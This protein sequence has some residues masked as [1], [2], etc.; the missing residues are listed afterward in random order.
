MS[1]R[2]RLLREFDFPPIPD[3]WEVINLSQILSSERGISVGVMYPGKHDPEGIPLIRAGDL[4][5]NRIEN[6]PEFRISKSVNQEYKRTILE[7]G[8]LLISLV[9]D[10]GRVAVVPEWAKGWN[11]ARAIGV[12]RISP[13]AEAKYVRLVLSTGPLQKIMRAWAN[14]T[15]QA[16]L[17]LKEIK[18]LPLPWPKKGV[19][20]NIVGIADA[21]EN[22]IELNRQMNRTLEQMARAL[23]KSWFIDFDPVHAKQRGEQPAGMDAET[24]ALFP[25]RFVEVDGKEVPE[26]WRIS[27]V[28][29]M[30]ENPRRSVNPQSIDGR[31]PYIGLEHMPRG[32]I[33]LD[34]WGKAEDID[35][36]KVIFEKGEVLF[37]RLRPYFKKV[38]IA[39][40]D[41]ISSIDILIL[42]PKINW[43]E[44]ALF[45]V[46]SDEFIDAM[47]GASGGTRMPRASWR[48]LAAYPLILPPETLA[49]AYSSAVA[50]IIE[51]I[52]MCTFESIE[53]AYIRNTLLPRLLSGEL[54]VSD[55]E[56]AVE[57]PESTPA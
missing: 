46:S 29:S 30:V 40:F 14:T 2:E 56:H 11:P 33:G 42:K 55:W 9:G 38:G 17:N 21:L 6:S 47:A 43:K 24:A 49:T 39:P 1:N 7:G 57:A 25:D 32:S 41:G 36:G 44:Y 27:Q 51:K 10:I 12:L 31:T 4:T 18:E 54:D 34:S 8:E 50:P 52:Q 5:G 48:D 37:G 13:Y 23:F 22:K 26:G 20:D 35:S 19:R 28:E 16:T 53:L 15:V 45:L 3:D